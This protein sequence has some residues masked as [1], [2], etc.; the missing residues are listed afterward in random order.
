MSNLI[1]IEN[2]SVIDGTGR[3]P[4]AA[5]VLVHG[6][7]IVAVGPQ[8][9]ER[10]AQAADVT[11]VD[12]TGMTVM[13]G[14]IDAHCHLSFDDA[15]S[16]PEIFHQR[17]NA[18]SALVA[19]YNAKKLL[20][21]GVTGILDP[22]SVHE[23]T[24]DLRDAIEAGVVDG[25][26]I[27]C[28]CYALITGVGGTG[29]RLIADEGVT[30][31]YKVVQGKDQIVAEVRRQIKVGADWIKVHVSGVVPR[32]AYRGEQCSWMQEELDLICQVAH[33][34]GV[35]VMG[36]CRGAEPIYRA[37]KA[38][39]DLIV[40]GTDMDE[41]GMELLLDRKIPVCPAFTFQANMVDFGH[42]LGTDPGLLKLFERQIINS[43]ESMRKL[44]AAGVPLLTGSEAGFSIVPYG[45]WHYREMEVFTRY[46]GMTNLQAIQCATQ[47]GAIALKM[48][49][50]V[51]TIS[52]GMK[53]DILCIDG[54]PSTQ[55]EVLG[56]PDRLKHVFLGGRAIDLSPL[57]ERK[58]ISGW[59][60]PT[61]G[62]R[63]SR[64]VMQGRAS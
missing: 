13:P 4:F 27:A 56:E 18:L 29:G 10:A 64:E 53:A 1:L 40:H 36:H 15:E 3:A 35:P 44:H 6:D 41:R 46:Y 51:G 16:N 17:R 57:P 38:G 45:L 33:D 23:N 39:M 28:G 60:Y 9:N 61:I 31:Y 30:G 50:K 43:A 24:V 26:R 59:K 37:A 54:D 63:L 20:R 47:H 32:Y 5:S 48:E 34:M 25:P 42:R 55:I 22:D 62:R 7:V 12:A 21:A 14:L 8:A 11:H 52:A 49:G 2:G 58:P 19:S